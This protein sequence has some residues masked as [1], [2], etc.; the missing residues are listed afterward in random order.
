MFD[1]NEH[2]GAQTERE[3]AFAHE[4]F[5]S[6]FYGLGGSFGFGKFQDKTYGYGD[7]EIG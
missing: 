7:D 5:R 2:F 4:N 6:S 3:I 1:W